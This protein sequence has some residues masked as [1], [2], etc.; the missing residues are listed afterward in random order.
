MKILAYLF[1][2]ALL[3]YI[4]VGL[5]SAA[6]WSRTYNTE[7]TSAPNNAASFI[8]NTLTWPW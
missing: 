2:S 8:I 1:A 5:W 7:R 3:L 6:K 4:V